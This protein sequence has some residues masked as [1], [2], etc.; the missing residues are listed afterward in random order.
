[1]SVP[2]LAFVALDAKC[3]TAWDADLLQDLGLEDAVTLRLA[4]EASA[5]S[6]CREILR[7]M[8]LHPES[9]R[10]KARRRERAER[11]RALLRTDDADGG[12]GGGG[13]GGC[14]PPKSPSA[15][16]RLAEQ[17]DMLELI[18]RVAANLHRVLD[19]ATASRSTGV[20]I[21]P[22]ACLL[23]HSCAPTCS[24]SF[25][26]EGRLLHVRALCDIEVGEEVTYSYLN[27][28]QLYA[29]WEER[30]ALLTAAHRFEAVEPSARRE[31]ER[32]TH[33]ASGGAGREGDVERGAR[34][35]RLKRQVHDEVSRAQRAITST[36][37]AA[38]D[39][40]AGRL[41]ELIERALQPA[42][43]PFHVLAQEAHAALLGVARVLDH[44]PLVARAALHLI[45][46]REFMLPRG[47]PHLASLYAA[48]AGA[49]LRLLREG[50][51]GKAERA[52]A[53]QAAA[54]SMRAALRIRSSCLGKEHP[55]TKSTAGALERANALATRSH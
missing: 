50:E 53:A 4:I 7:G 34:M 30:S 12:G 31:A 37:P 21:F 1:M 9:P 8:V 47:T 16:V 5:T 6:S 15:S 54:A 45:A 42:L 38:L 25:A 10:E 32:Q 29:S 44:P 17:D 27:E 40:A 48:H 33:V 41:E 18:S 22:A 43:H 19:D 52:Q 49:V 23:N 51:I 14:D 20:G 55:L 36:S 35:E 3:N 13:G 2:A 24:F 46:A 26:A 11:V 28:E 39:A